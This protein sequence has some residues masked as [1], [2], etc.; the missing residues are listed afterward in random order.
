MTLGGTNLPDKL[1]VV[2][3]QHGSYDYTENH[4]S[5]FVVW[6]TT[7]GYGQASFLVFYNFDNSPA[8]EERW[9]GSDG[10]VVRCRL[11]TRSDMILSPV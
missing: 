8:D 2:R 9:A 7:L 10:F 5:V 4:M 6:P 1:L 11:L 3:C